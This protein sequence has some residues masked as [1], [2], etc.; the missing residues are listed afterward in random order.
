MTPSVNNHRSGDASFIHNVH[1]PLGVIFGKRP[2]DL[3][4]TT[5]GSSENDNGIFSEQLW[6][7]QGTALGGFPEQIVAAIDEAKASAWI[8]TKKMIPEL[9]QFVSDEDSFTH[10]PIANV[11]EQEDDDEDDA[12]AENEEDEGDLT[13]QTVTANDDSDESDESDGEDEEDD[14]FQ[15][16]YEAEVPEE[17]LHITES[18]ETNSLETPVVGDDAE[19]GKSMADPHLVKGRDGRQ[20]PVTQLV[21]KFYGNKHSNRQH[22]RLQRFFENEPYQIMTNNPRG[23]G[24][25]ASLLDACSLSRNDFVV[26]ASECGKKRRK[27]SIFAGKIMWFVNY[28]DVKGKRRGEGKACANTM[29]DDVLLKCY[30]IRRDGEIQP[31]KIRFRLVPIKK[32][33]DQKYKLQVKDGKICAFNRNQFSELKELL[34]SLSAER[35]LQRVVE[36]KNAIAR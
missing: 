25:A 17:I 5:T 29:E 31:S 2:R 16:D 27:D 34:K 20:Y 26:F 36:G 19:G 3:R 10:D 4:K 21:L 11:V 12:D 7:L 8:S 6:D 15:S 35:D 32:L 9:G 13:Q 1:I 14:D 24:A 22:S 23:F 30:R 33:C 18:N 28:Y